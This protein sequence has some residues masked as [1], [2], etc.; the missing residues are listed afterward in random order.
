[1]PPNFEA[2]TT[3]ANSNHHWFRFILFQL[4]LATISSVSTR[5]QSYYDSQP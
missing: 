4:R 5:N 3:A 1:M 2:N